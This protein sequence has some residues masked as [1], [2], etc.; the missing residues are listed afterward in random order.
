[1]ISTHTRAHNQVNVDYLADIEQVALSEAK[2][3]QVRFKEWASEYCQVGIPLKSRPE[4]HGR[5]LR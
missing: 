4:A 1:M 3:H 5:R 2:K